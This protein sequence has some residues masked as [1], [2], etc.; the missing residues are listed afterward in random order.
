[1]PV[2]ILRVSD[3]QQALPMDRVVQAV[4]EAFRAHGNH[5]TAMPPKVYL[6]LPAHNGDFRAM[7]AALEAYAGIKWVNSHP[8][9]PSR[10]KLPTVMGMYILSDAQTAVPLSIMDGT[11]LTAMRT[12]AA[13]AVATKH[14]MEPKKRPQS[15]GI[16]GAGVQAQ[17][18]LEAHRCLYPKLD[19]YISDVQQDRAE[20]FAQKHNAKSVNVEKACGCD[21]LCTATPSKKPLVFRNW[22]KE[23]AH[24]NAMGADAP[25][26]QELETQILKDAFLVVDD[27]KQASE[28][29]EINVPYAK[30]ALDRSHIA[31]ELGE[32]IAN[33]AKAPIPSTT[34]TV[35]DS[36]GLAVQDL[37]VAALAFGEAKKLGLGNEVDFGA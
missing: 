15:L 1:M 22:I 24:V 34:I 7:P 26:K 9:N 19:V 2:R 13:A 21:V 3:L 37:A 6:D 18:L 36:T 25:L 28:S 23:G 8:D 33:K 4:E 12:G 29:G 5:Q 17:Y 20:D 35:F 31:A 10:H 11:L 16:I 30:G 27:W 32:I 14:L